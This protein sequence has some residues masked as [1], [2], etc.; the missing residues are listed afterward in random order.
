MGF[1]GHRENCYMTRTVIVHVKSVP[2][3]SF[4]TPLYFLNITFRFKRSKIQQHSNSQQGI[5]QPMSIE[6][7]EEES[8]DVP[9]YE[10]PLHGKSGFLQAIL[11]SDKMAL[12]SV[13]DCISRCINKCINN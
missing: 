12:R 10:S 8:Y 5:Q 3:V 2:M 1:L 4:L 7:Q 11:S 6:L 9:E 13:M